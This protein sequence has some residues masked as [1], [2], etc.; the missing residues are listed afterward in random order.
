VAD[1]IEYVYAPGSPAVAAET[2]NLMRFLSDNEKADAQTG[3]LAYDL[4][5]KIQAALNSLAATGGQLECPGGLTLGISSDINI[6]N[7]VSF[8]C[9]GVSTIRARAGAVFTRAM[10]ICGEYVTPG[11]TFPNGGYGNRNGTFSNFTL[12]GGAIAPILLYVGGA[13]QRYFERL[14]GTNAAG[15]GLVIDGAQNNTFTSCHFESNGNTTS[16]DAANIVFDRG[17]GNNRIIGSEFSGRSTGNGGKY[18]VLFRQS[19]ASPDG[20]FAVPTRNVISHSVVERTAASY[21]A[22]IC[23]RAGAENIFD[24]VDIH[25]WASVPVIEGNTNDGSNYLN[26]FSSCRISGASAAT[27]ISLTNPYRWRID[28]CTFE[29][30]PVGITSSAA[31]SVMISGYLHESVIGT[32]FAGSIKVSWDGGGRPGVSSNR[33]D[34]NVTLTHGTDYVTQQ[35]GTPLTANRTVTLDATDIAPSAKFRIIR[36]TTAASPY[37][38]T[39]TGGGVSRVLMGGDW[40]DVEYTG[41]DW[42]VTAGSPVFDSV[43]VKAWGATGNGTTD[44]QP[45]VQACVAANPGKAIVFPRP[46]TAYRF[47]AGPVLVQSNDTQLIAEGKMPILHNVPNDD[48]FRFAPV[49]LTTSNFL[50]GCR[51]LG[52]FL[53]YKAPGGTDTLGAGVRLHKVNN[54]TLADVSTYNLPSGVVVEGGQNIRLHRLNLQNDASSVDMTAVTDSA[55][56]KIL[57]AACS[58]STYQPNYTTRIVDLN[59]GA[60]YRT[61]CCMLIGNADGIQWSTSYL[62][63]GYSTIL[64]VK[65]QRNGGYIVALTAT[66]VYFD[67]VSS[68]TGSQ[69]C[70]DIPD[71]SYASAAIYNLTFNNCFFGNCQEDAI[72]V[73]KN[74]TEL[75]ITGGTIANARGHGINFTGQAAYIGGLHVTGVKIQ[76]TG[77]GAGAVSAIRVGHAIHV[78]LGHNK[79]ETFSGTNSCLRLDGNIADCLIVGNSIRTSTG[80]DYTNAGTVVRL[81]KTAN[82]SSYSPSTL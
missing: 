5:P 24:N 68:S 61:Q 32:M 7:G 9:S 8:T 31:G 47:V 18:N 40:C 25:A 17:A 76:T 20:G 69:R 34:A 12:N 80:P 49:G 67:A 1:A 36:L 6:P 33:G 55:L 82:L 74:V 73:T 2:A 45:Y 58:G 48:A 41:G 52:T 78:N 62:A 10:V 50:S 26:T 51:M 72:R 39:V 21:L 53:I 15:S 23:F 60:G 13:V 11:G 54:F 63:S 22:S 19:A 59:I 3:G 79:I 70:L 16:V 35:F 42:K 64:R 56:L 66:A 77:V 44:D 27:G 29:A 43:N 46:A 75:Q 65:N 38:L 14:N 30:C 4:Q 37:T 28:S 57:E 81:Q 71:D